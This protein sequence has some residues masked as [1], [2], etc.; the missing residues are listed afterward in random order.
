[1]LHLLSASCH[2]QNAGI[3]KK[4]AQS[5]GIA[6]DHRRKNKSVRGVCAH[7][8]LV[9]VCTVQGSCLAHVAL[10]GRG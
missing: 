2:E 1:M 8:S 7:R 4:L 9:D 3:S 5:I 10:W 6:V